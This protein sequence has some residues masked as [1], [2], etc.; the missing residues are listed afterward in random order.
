[1]LG[2][3]EVGKL[4]NKRK[5]SQIPRSTPMGTKKL[6]ITYLVAWSYGAA[7]TLLNLSTTF[8]ISN[9]PSFFGGFVANNLAMFGWVP[10]IFANSLLIAYLI[11]SAI[12]LLG[13]FVFYFVLTKE[14]LRLYLELKTSTVLGVLG[15]L[16]MFSALN[17]V[18][19]Q[20]FIDLFPTTREF[21]LMMILFPFFLPLTLLDEFWLRN[22]QNRLSNK[23]WQKIG[24]PFALYLLPK[25]IPLGFAS[26]VFGNLVLIALPILFTPALFTAWLFNESKSIAGGVIFNALLFAW[27][28]AVVLPFGGYF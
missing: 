21:S 18:F 16:V 15:F 3:K 25:V 5:I 20:N 1:M 27:I 2:V 9:T 8:L 14:K 23:S 19:T 22:L 12:L 4:I 6:L 13:I 17:L 26:F 28:I 24:I 10:V 11:V 7:G